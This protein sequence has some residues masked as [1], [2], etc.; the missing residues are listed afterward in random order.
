[1]TTKRRS[2][3]LLSWGSKT[4]YFMTLIACVAAGA[5]AYL[6]VP[7]FNG[8]TTASAQRVEFPVGVRSGGERATPGM[9]S[10]ALGNRTNNLSDMISAI[11][12]LPCHEV[13]D[14]ELGGKSFAPG[15]YCLSSARLAGEMTLNGENDPNSIFIFNVKNSLNTERNSKISL[16]GQT[17]VSNVFFVA[18]TVNIGENTDFRSA[19]LSKNAVSL[20]GTARVSGK[21][22]SLGNPTTEVADSPNGDGTGTLEICKAVSSTFGDLQNRIFQFRVTGV[23]IP[24]PIVRTVRAGFCTAPFDVPNGPA[25]V[26]E[27]NEGFTLGGAPV[28]GNFLLT[29]VRVIQASTPSP[30]SLG[31]VNLATRTAAI[32]VADSSVNNQLTLEFT[33]RFA[34]T[35]FVEICKRALDVDVVGTFTYNVEGVFVAGSNTVLQPFTAPVGQCTGAIA[36]TRPFD[37]QEGPAP[38]R[39]VVRVTELGQNGSFL[40]SV[41]TIPTD[42]EL[43]QEVLGLGINGAGGTYTNSGGGYATVAVLEGSASL[44]TI[45]NFRNRSRPGLLKVCKIAG[46]GITPNSLFSFTVTGTGPTTAA[47]TTNGIVTRTFNVA[48]GPPAD[49]GTCAFVPGFGAG[50]G[51]AEFQTF[52]IGSTITV[53]ENP[54]TVSDGQIRVA[55][56][57]TT[58]TGSR[59]SEFVTNVIARRDVIE[60]EYTN[61]LFRPTILKVCKIGLQGI[62]PNTPFTFNVALVSPVGAG[63]NLFPAF[64]TTVTVNSGSS[65]QGGNCN[66]VE[67]GGL[68]G[69]AFN[70]GSTVTITEPAVAGTIVTDIS[71][72]TSILFP[73]VF[74][75]GQRSTTLQG[76]NGLVPGVTQVTFVNA[77]SAT[78]TPTPT[79]TPLPRGRAYDFDG[80]NKAD[81]SVFRPATGTWFINQSQNGFTGV[82]FGMENDRIAPADYDGDGRTDIAVYRAGMWYLQRSTLGFT[83]I[84][85]GEANDIPMP[86]DYDGDNKADIAVFRPA[87]GTWYIQQSTAGFTAITFGQAGDKPVAADY[88]GDGKADIAINRGGTW[89]IQRSTLGFTGIA[90]GDA[91]DKPVPADYDGDGKTDVAVY[92]P[93]NGTWYL[94]RSQAGFTGISFGMSS[95]VPSP[96]DYDGDGRT[97]VAVFRPS[98]GTWYA[99]RSTAGFI[100]VP[101]G[102]D[103]DK[104]VPNAFV[105]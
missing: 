93:S 83:G 31:V 4:L 50:A 86:A 65:G 68:I 71:S 102:M 28:S 59:P 62:A 12:Q 98:N 8:A 46:P 66:I 97:D 72:T 99:N 20:D 40:E 21:I 84:M 74:V 14:T 101:F 44:E 105:R 6:N 25:V 18:D 53:T 51:N 23:N 2:F 54:P 64:S 69:G 32:T 88:D 89:Y 48:A 10:Y 36:V 13:A 43:V 39:G 75:P 63:G 103:V 76:P 81:M 19:V 55:R 96:A 11:S 70:Q 7:N 61:F 27:L 35:G 77:G 56:V 49:G 79:P 3:S 38:R 92:R 82:I 42:R 37:G 78:P 41:D 26:T 24:V 17:R 60:V 91:A 100:A 85:F 1:M 15:V 29:N 90:F 30:S 16:S 22:L 58:S 73:A 57:R 95:D 80:D 34:I 104:S 67:G 5:A 47:G 94:L 9:I 33:N 45:V 52:V 87:T